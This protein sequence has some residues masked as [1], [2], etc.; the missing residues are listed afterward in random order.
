MATVKNK[1]DPGIELENLNC[2]TANVI[3]DSSKHH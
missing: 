1:K 3:I 2:A